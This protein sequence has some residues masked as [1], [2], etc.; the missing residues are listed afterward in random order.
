MSFSGINSAVSAKS[1]YK[2]TLITQSTSCFFLS[3]VQN[4][5]SQLFNSSTVSIDNLF[6]QS[7]SCRDRYQSIPTLYSMFPEHSRKQGTNGAHRTCPHFIKCI[8]YSLLRWQ[9]SLQR[10]VSTLWNVYLS[11]STT[12]ISSIS[13][14]HRHN[15]P[16]TPTINTNH[17]HQP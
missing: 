7:S 5:P 15:Q 16:S 1:V 3:F 4:P 9:F 2:R 13:I 14:H 17:Q 8:H 10:S 6:C 11:T 12:D